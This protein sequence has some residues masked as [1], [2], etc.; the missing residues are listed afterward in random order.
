E[1]AKAAIIFSLEALFGAVGGAL[2]LGERMRPLGYLGCGMIF[3][4]IIVSQASGLGKRRKREGVR[5]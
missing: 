5:L 1:P 2:L 3:C 4:G